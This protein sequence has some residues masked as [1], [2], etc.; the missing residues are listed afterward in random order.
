MRSTSTCRKAS[1][2]PIPSPVMNE[3]RTELANQLTDGYSGDKT[4]EQAMD[5]FIRNSE[6]IVAKAAR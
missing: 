6:D 4:P 5:D 1:R 2:F 3:V